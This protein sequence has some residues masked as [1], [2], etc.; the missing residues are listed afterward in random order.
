[1]NIT[2][3]GSG[4]V[5]LVSGACLSEMGNNVVCVDTDQ[6]KIDGLRKGVIPIYEPGLETLVQ[7]NMA[8][9]RLS[10]TTSIEQ[11]VKH[12]EVI[13]IA[14]GT[15]PDED[16]AAD[17][18]YVQRVAQSI[19][20]QINDYRVV[21]TKSTVPVGTAGMVK[22]T[23]NQ[24]LEQR[25]LSIAFS[26]VSNPEFLKVGAAVEDFMKP[27]R[28]IVGVE[29][30][31]ALDV[32]R[33]LYAPFN[34]NHERLIVM[35]VA[36]AELTKYTAN[37][38]LA[39]K[40]SF[41]NEISN[42]A[43]CLGADIESVRIGIGAD[44]RIGYSFIYPGC[45]YGGSCFS[46]DVQALHKTAKSVNYDA[47][48]LSAVEAVNNDQ[49]RVPVNKI[50]GHFGTDLKDKKFALWGLSFKP[51]T[52]D[53]RG[54]PSRV[55]MEALWDMGA[56]V[57]AFDPVA[58]AEA[59]RIYGERDDL[60]LFSD[61]PYDALTDADCLII[62]TE[63]RVFRGSDIAQIKSKM[64]GNVI[65]DGRNIFSPETVTAAGLSYYG[66]GRP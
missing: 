27:D 9:D 10:F 17:L 40:I 35:D 63:W 55:I 47:R 8:S 44:P 45:G 15:P 13:F 5:G 32:L 11:G 28:I 3:V 1:M 20:E 14:V 19:G 64:R 30:D 31:R 26:V 2:V 16:G 25:G 59:L 12:G 42:L 33:N 18:Q 21:I 54:A 6:G 22:T 23:I 46:K 57:Q 4:Y 51:D 43:D 29:D 65:V 38:M 7:K 66:I 36:S 56:S 41:M 53:M 52:D 24:A 39:T 58:T 37:A 60:T 49:K 50:V 48:I 61:T 62:V 34:R